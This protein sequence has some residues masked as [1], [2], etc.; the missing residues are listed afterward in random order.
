M[1]DDPHDDWTTSLGILLLSLKKEESLEN[2][3][4]PGYNSYKV[5]HTMSSTLDRLPVGPTN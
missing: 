1:D 3:R 4:D 2:D 5:T